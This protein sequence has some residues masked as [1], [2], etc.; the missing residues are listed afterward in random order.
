MI[1]IKENLIFSLL[2]ILLKNLNHGHQDLE[3]FRGVFC[4]L[5]KEQSEEIKN[6]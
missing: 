1:K 2:K 5:T 3:V 4:K 6:K